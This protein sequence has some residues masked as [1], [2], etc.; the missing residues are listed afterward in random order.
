M[1][2]KYSDDYHILSSLFSAVHAF[3]SVLSMVDGILLP[4]YVNSVTALMLSFV[5]DLIEPVC[6]W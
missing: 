5:K 6:S 4:R 1:R 2:Q 3:P